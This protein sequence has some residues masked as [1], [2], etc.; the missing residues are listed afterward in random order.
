MAGYTTT[1]IIG[2]PSLATAAKGE[3]ALASLVASFAD[4]LKILNE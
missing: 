4:H 2:Y 1:G 3:A